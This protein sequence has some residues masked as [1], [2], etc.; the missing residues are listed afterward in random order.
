M[1]SPYKNF[2]LQDSKNQLKQVSDSVNNT[3][4]NH[5]NVNSLYQNVRYKYDINII[6]LMSSLHLLLIYYFDIGFPI[7]RFH[8]LPN[9]NY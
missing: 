4:V 2:S 8:S 9:A 6:E 5:K 3:V 1:Y 7:S